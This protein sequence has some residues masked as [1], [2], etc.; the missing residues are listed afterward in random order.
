[1]KAVAS[2]IAR[3]A[4]AAVLLCIA[5][6]GQDARAQ[7]HAGT[8][9][10]V[11]G[12]AYAQNAAGVRQALKIGVAFE[13]GVTFHT[14][15]NES[16]ELR[17]ADG[18]VLII[19]RNSTLKIDRFAYS[20]ANSNAN[21]LG[22]SLDEGSL[23]FIGGNIASGQPSAVQISAGPS[24]V[25]LLST[26]G[27]DFTLLVDNSSGA[28]GLAAVTRGEIRL[29][30]P[31]GAIESI[32]RDQVA[33]WQPTGVPA[34]APLV[35][36]PAVLLAQLT[37][38][39][40]Q[41]GLGQ[42]GTV[43]TV[44]G[45]VVADAPSGDRSRVVAGA[46]FSEGTTFRTGVRESA[47]LVLADGQVVL[48]GQSSTVRIDRFTFDNS[49]DGQSSKSAFGVTVLNG[50]MRFVGG[51]IASSQPENVQIRAG[52]ADVGI[53]RQGGADFTVGVG[54]GTQDTGALAVRTGEVTLTSPQGVVTSVSAGQGA[55]WQLGV[56]PTLGP[57]ASMPAAIL[58]DIAG[59]PPTSI[60]S[61]SVRVAPTETGTNGVESVI[62]GLE[63]PGAGESPADIPA[64]P[65]VVL[66]PGGGGGCTGSPC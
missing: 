61:L 14:A 48:I 53:T 21:A 60:E 24:T 8:V 23:R 12:N 18:Q 46:R 42:A 9:R 4:S 25:S 13:A 63:A 30:T 64:L 44:T 27:V 7:S 22:I 54:L 57:I 45:N 33:R 41:D 11:T 3:C 51:A 16:L 40:S 2:G 65:P 19:G 1:M 52:E 38:M 17:L 31:Y 58:A 62:A 55:T 26:G 49:L 32:T 10:A 59:I 39:Q 35:S 29:V 37:A 50:L 66:A 6:L 56:N 47:E 34:A 5:L 36:L 15:G 43:R 20:A 28:A